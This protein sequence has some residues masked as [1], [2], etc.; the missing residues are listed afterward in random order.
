MSEKVGGRVLDVL[1][2]ILSFGRCT[3]KNDVV[4]P[5]WS[6]SEEGA[7]EAFSSRVRD[8]GMR[9]LLFFNYLSG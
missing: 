1:Q 4:L 8:G 5:V 6:W 3:E 2:I 9:L 7:D